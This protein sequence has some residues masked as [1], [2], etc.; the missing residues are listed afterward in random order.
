[1]RM[2]WER[3]VMMKRIELSEYIDHL[4][5]DL[6]QI[7]IRHI[8]SLGIDSE[9]VTLYGNFY[10]YVNDECTD[11]TKIS[12]KSIHCNCEGQLYVKY[13]EEDNIFSEK[14]EQWQY[15]DSLETQMLLDIVQNIY[16]RKA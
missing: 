12:W 4:E 3:G 11:I 1:M 13:I 8:R 14:K 7:I 15:L 5:S 16:R 2:T 10:Y 6:R 9:P